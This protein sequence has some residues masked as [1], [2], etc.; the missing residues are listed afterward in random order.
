MVKHFSGSFDRSNIFKMSSLQVTWV[1]KEADRVHEAIVGAKLKD[2][3][4]I[5]MELIELRM[6]N[7]S[8]KLRDWNDKSNLTASK[9]FGIGFGIHALSSFKL[10]F[11]DFYI[12]N[13]NYS[14]YFTLALVYLRT[15]KYFKRIKLFLFA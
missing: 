4:G 10:E 7:P 5:I 2:E 12:L 1:V 15:I 6:I 11:K 13:Y 3:D 14:F 8:K 9:K